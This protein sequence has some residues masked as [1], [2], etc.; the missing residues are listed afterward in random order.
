M[1]YFVIF[2]GLFSK[3]DC[4]KVAIQRDDENLIREQEQA[5]IKL[6]ELY[7]DQR[8]PH[9]LSN[10]I[11]S[12]RS[13][14]ASISRAKTAKI[15][16]T[17][18]DLF[19]EIP[20]T[21]P[22]QIEICKETID[23][24]VQEKRIF[25]KQSLETRLVALY[26]D[27]KMYHDALTLINS[28]LKELR[29]LDDKMVLVEVQL[30]ESRVCHAL[31][32][33]PKSRAALTSARTSAN[34]IYCPPLLQAALDMQSGILH[35]EDK[36]YKTA[37]S[38]FYETLEGYSSQDD[39]RAILALKY[40]LLCKIMLNL[41]ED[42]YSIIN[43]KLA[44]RYAGRE[45]EAMKAVAT[46][47]QNR[48]LNEFETALKTYSDELE[49]DPI[50]RS[51]LAALY[52]TLLEQN[53]VRIIEPFSRVEISHVA[54]IV[55]LPTSHVETK[56]SQMILDKVFH[57]ILD[58]GAGCLI[59]FDEPPQD[60]TYEAALETLKQ[61]GNVVESLYEKNMH[62]H[63]YNSKYRSSYFKE[64]QKQAENDALVLAESVLLWLTNELGYRHGR[65]AS[66]L[67]EVT[68]QEL[69]KE[70]IQKN[71]FVPILKFLME[72]VKSSKEADQIRKSLANNQGRIKKSHQ[73][74]RNKGTIS[75]SGSSFT[76]ENH[77]QRKLKLEKKLAQSNEVFQE[78]E[79]QVTQLISRIADV[80][81]QIRSVK[82]EISEKKNKIYMKQVFR[83][84]CKNFMNSEAEYRKLLEKSRSKAGPKDELSFALKEDPLKSTSPKALL[85][86]VLN[87]MRS[88]AKDL[89][90]KSEQFTGEKIITD[91]DSSRVQRMLYTFM[92]DH[93]SRFF[94]V[95]KI[96]NDIIEINEKILEK[97]ASIKF[98]VEQKYSHIPSIS[99]RIISVINAKADS[100]AAQA[101]LNMASSFAEELE[102]RCQE[103]APLSDELAEIADRVSGS[104]EIIKQKQKDIQNLISVNQQT[105]EGLLEQSQEISRFIQEELSP[106]KLHFES[107]TKDLDC[108][109][110]QE[111]E[112]FQDLDLKLAVQA[113]LNNNSQ[114]VS[115]LNIYRVL[116]D[117]FIGEIKKLLH[118][119]MYLST[120][121]ILRILADL[122]REG[123]AF[124][125]TRNNL[126]RNMNLC[127]N[128]MQEI[129]NRW[130]SS[131]HS[132]VIEESV[133]NKN[134]TYE[135]TIKDMESSVESLSD[136]LEK[137]EKEFFEKQIPRIKEEIE[138][139]EAAENV[140]KEIQEI[141]EE[142]SNKIMSGGR[143]IL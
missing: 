41:S 64:K 82:D 56:L 140:Y 133:F 142:H 77:A 131:I 7:R 86:S 96:L 34:A 111:N 38:Y 89:N 132:D 92:K 14:M 105:R 71:E 78:T 103:L 117:K 90:T 138:K 54:E 47:H 15:V 31:R 28:L 57:G 37:Y 23:W 69:T 29:R 122:K 20:E 21:L 8:K 88:A 1:A 27:N 123:A 2:M 12:S 130:M 61:M 58:Q 119:P 87:A 81:S 106:F 74:K 44:L 73:T 70:D 9:E 3:R 83:E 112:Q 33:V 36:D 76:E 128:E 118:C 4:D 32:N 48:S 85:K 141:I 39:P 116:Y 110:L 5:L 65:S 80:E 125:I 68:D 62:S 59:V 52:D 35:A 67:E 43:G 10:L 101:A 11:R 55:K 126:I 51:H 108:L 66:I 95:E 30:L 26:L 143:I 17:L 136:I 113:K 109:M 139:S 102:K 84:N 40:M 50:I 98:H 114:A 115:S 93:A 72:H 22:L 13:F 129:V 53:L 137:Q 99:N 25:L 135:Q 100:E 19:A 94:E 134:I 104:N 45:V 127:H 79:Q 6:G 60:K 97:H 120:D 16:K 91:D 75:S 18:I 42:V 24:S 124:E 107:L 63:L 121:C 49:N 46:A